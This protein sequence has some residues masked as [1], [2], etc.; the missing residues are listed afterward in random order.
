MFTLQ[1]FCLPVISAVALLFAAQ[2]APAT[3]AQPGIEGVST[4]QVI[5]TVQENGEISSIESLGNN[6]LARTAAG[7]AP[8]CINAVPEKGFVQ[9]YNNCDWD[10]RVK[11]VFAF[12]PDSACKL[13]LAGTR[14]NI[15]LHL[16]RIDGVELC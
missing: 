6:G 12:S 14:T 8:D 7:R 16:G 13:V 11:V 10:M 1:K 2:Q 9:V 5:I 4:S 15:S 3:A